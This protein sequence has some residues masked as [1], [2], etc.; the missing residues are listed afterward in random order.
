MWRGQAPLQ[1]ADKILLTET[2]FAITETNVF[3]PEIFTILGSI[4]Q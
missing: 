4:Q 2:G 1:P 3:G